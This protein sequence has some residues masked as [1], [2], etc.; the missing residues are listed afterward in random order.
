[1]AALSESESESELE[2]GSWARMNGVRIVKRRAK[3]I[4]RCILVVVGSFDR[5]NRM[6]IVG[7]VG[8][9]NKKVD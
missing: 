6:G 1:M 8:G 3:G 9:L 5:L 4:W 7:K 2:L